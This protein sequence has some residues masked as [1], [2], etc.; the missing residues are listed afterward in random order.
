MG[1]TPTQQLVDTLESVLKKS[2]M[3]ITR[4]YEPKASTTAIVKQLSLETLQDR[5]KIDKATMVF[6]IKNQ[7]VDIKEN[8][9]F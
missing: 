8:N 2:A 1:P 3:R 9:H 6:R 4:D 5:K 7:H